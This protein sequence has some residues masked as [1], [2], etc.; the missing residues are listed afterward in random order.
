MTKLIKSRILTILKL[1][2]VDH[3]KNNS[4]QMFYRRASLQNYT[5]VRKITY[6]GALFSVIF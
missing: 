6:D 1:S 3:G 5:K 2:E 4:P